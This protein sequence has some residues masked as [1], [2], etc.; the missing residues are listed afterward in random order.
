TAFSRKM[1][2]AVF[3]ATTLLQAA[4]NR[5]GPAGA[6]LAFVDE[7]RVKVFL[8]A[9]VLEEV[10][11]V[12]HRPSI[13]SAFPKLTDDYVSE[14][15]ELLVEKGQLVNTVSAAYRFDRDPDDEPYLNLAIAVK[16]EYLVSRDKD[17][18]SLM[19]NEEFRTIYPSLVIL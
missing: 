5:S 1:I 6:C 4:T 13:R 18:L 10:H 8:S 16:A 3:D 7:G 12:L 15:L 2:S 11:D 17:L 19:E 9:A 14:F